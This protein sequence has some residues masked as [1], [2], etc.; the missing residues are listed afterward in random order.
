MAGLITGAV[1]I[2]FA[3]VVCGLFT[4]PM[5][6]VKGWEWENTW[7]LYSLFGQFIFPWVI[8]MATVPDVFGNKNGTDGSI[9]I[10]TE[11][12]QDHPMDI[13]KVCLFGAGWGIGG[14]LFGL[15]CQA[16]G[17]SL[18]FSIILGL[19]SALGTVIPLLVL[20]PEEAG[21][22]E[23]IY[24]W[25]GLFIVIIGLAVLAKAGGRKDQEQKPAGSNYAENAPLLSI[26][27]DDVP[28]VKKAGGTSFALGLVICLISGAF[29]PMLSLAFNFG[30]GIV[31][32]TKSHCAA[33]AG[34]D[35]DIVA[36]M[37]VWPPAVNC[38]CIVNLIFCF[39]KLTVN[40]TWG[41]FME[42]PV[43]KNWFLGALMGLLWFGG[44]IL[45]G[46]GGTLVPGS[47]G[48]VIGWPIFMV[49]MV[50]CANVTGVMYGEWKG[51]SKKTMQL[52]VTG[53][54]LLLIATIV[55][56]LG[57]T[58]PKGSS[59]S[60]NTTTTTTTHSFEAFGPSF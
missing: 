25:I 49:G 53:L 21:Q 16:V 38:G 59:N 17:D 19:T 14:V 41:K 44:N 7:T 30:G 50:L 10:Y 6:F 40:K 20:T 26:N 28:A 12:A 22:K 2:L 56:A 51:T 8:V 60:T 23:G 3:G 39:Y 27:P 13:V 5:R 36:S 42:G 29:S 54:V 11:V 9:S 4:F 43:L 45:Y 35:C 33:A 57:K 31:N 18:G 58:A 1:L 55:I 34:E 32:A 46:I 47:T 24:T 15:G 52:L 37:S 48:A